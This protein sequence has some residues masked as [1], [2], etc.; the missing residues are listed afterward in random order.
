MDKDT[1]RFLM[2]L[3]VE[4]NNREDEEAKEA[5]RKAGIEAIERR[6]TFA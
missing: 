4:N 2:K 6:K 3:I 1:K 5:R